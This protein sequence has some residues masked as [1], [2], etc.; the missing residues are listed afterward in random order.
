MRIGFVGIGNMGS[1]IA[2]R[3]MEE[4]H[5]LTVHDLR[6]E[7][8]TDLCE[9]GARWA[10]SPIAVAQAPDGEHV[11]VFT[12]LPGPT[13]VEKVVM[14]RDSGIL[15]G[16]RPGSAYIDLTTNSPS[17]FRRVAEACRARGVEVLD[18]PVSGRPPEM[19]IM[20]GGEQDTFDRYKPLLEQIGRNVFHV[21]ETGTGCI[22]KLVSQYLGYC[23]FIAAAEG[24]L[25]GA[26]AGIDLDVLARIIPVS[27]GASRTFGSFPNSV[28]S[29]GFAAGG[30]LD[31]VAKDIDLACQLAREVQSPAHIGALVDDVLKRAQAQGWGP[32]GFPIAVR[33]LEEMAG[34][35]LRAPGG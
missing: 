2:R 20:V 24:L 10:D 16:L 35:Q 28:F 7:A 31:I 29:G 17:T 23:N 32:E 34:A 12:S 33:V 15:A 14:D 25:I 21:G 13:E 3:L 19:T 27:A 18:A 1:P 22:A 11:V 5:Q 9:M 30:T 8:T 4:G 6:R 26:K